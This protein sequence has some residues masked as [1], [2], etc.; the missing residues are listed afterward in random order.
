L[1]FVRSDLH[2][3]FAPAR[4]PGPHH[5]YEPSRPC[6]PRYSAPRGFRRLGSS[7]SRPAGR[8][9]ARSRHPSVPRRQVLLFHASACDELT[10]PLHRAPPGPHAG[11]FLA[12][13]A[14]TGRAFVP[15]TSPSPGFDADFMSFDASA[16]V[17][18]RSSSRRAPDPVSPG[19]FPGRSPQRLFTAAAPGGLGSPP[20]RRT[21]RATSSITGTARFVLVTF[22]I[23]T[24]LLSRTHGLWTWSEIWCDVEN[25]K[26]ASDRATRAAFPQVTGLRVEELYIIILHQFFTATGGRVASEPGKWPGQKRSDPLVTFAMLGVLGLATSAFHIKDDRP[27]PTMMVHRSCSERGSRRWW[28]QVHE[29]E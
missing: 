26:R 8:A 23:T 1:A 19:L 2:G 15:G 13:D 12:E 5:Y 4:L 20:A 29:H 17:H 25:S 18:A 22:Y 27:G 14:P 6:A 9:A 16:V 24:T 21:R 7:L 28:T 10:P 3:S 11:R